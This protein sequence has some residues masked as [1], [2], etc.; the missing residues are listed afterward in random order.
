MY[1]YRMTA[2]ILPAMVIATFSSLMTDASAQTTSANCKALVEINQNLWLI[3]GN[4][5]PLAQLTNDAKFKSASAMHSEGA[6]IAYSV[7]APSGKIMLIDSAGRLLDTTDL[8]ASDPIVDLKWMTPTL[9]RAAEHVGP[10]ASHHHFLR[11]ESNNRLTVVPAPAGSGQSCALSSD[12]AETACTIGDAV[13]LNGRDIYFATDAFASSSNL[14]ATDVAAGT[15][16]S[17]GTTPA[18]RVEVKGIVGNTVALRVTTPDGL[19]QE[20]YVAS[21]SAMPVVSEG[22]GP[23]TYY[24]LKP[25]IT[26]NTG[27][28]RLTF[29]LSKTGPAVFDPVIAWDPRGK[30]IAVVDVNEL[31]KRTWVLLNRQMG[32]AA[33]KSYG[34]IDAKEPLPIDGPIKSITFSS[35]TRIRIEGAQVFEKD[36]PAQGKVPKGTPFTVTQELALPSV[37]NVSIGGFQGA[38]DVKGWSCR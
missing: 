36:I 33:N 25:V 20:Q 18:L 34:A 3:K 10:N 11:L 7:Q 37:V 12:G 9:L 22:D 2:A 32:Q 31:G 28:V 14:Q 13:S 35:D 26:A 19:W 8:N 21:G 30:R 4:G 38:T 17:I 1:T 15:S 16:I 23:Q 24:G 29:S 6:L 5:Q 27:V